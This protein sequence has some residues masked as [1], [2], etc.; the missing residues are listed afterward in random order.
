MSEEWFCLKVYSFFVGFLIL[1]ISHQSYSFLSSKSFA[2]DFCFSEGLLPFVPSLLSKYTL[3]SPAKTLRFFSKKFM[4][5]RSWL[6]SVKTSTCST[7]VLALG[8]LARTYL[9]S[10]MFTSRIRIHPFLSPTCL[11]TQTLRFS[12]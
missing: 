12:K 10:P 6:S 1:Q 11:L 7:S 5:F 8:I 4:F 9:I 3:R 2:T